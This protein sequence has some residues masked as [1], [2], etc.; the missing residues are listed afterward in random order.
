MA[1]FIILPSTLL[2][3]GSSALPDARAD[4]SDSHNFIPIDLL[5]GHPRGIILPVP[6]SWNVALGPPA[7]CLRLS[8]RFA[9]SS[10]IFAKTTR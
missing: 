9:I 2:S 6:A 8:S 10:Y 5:R 7:F 4:A 1:V 3:G